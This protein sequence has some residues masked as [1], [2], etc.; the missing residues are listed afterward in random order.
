MCA[1]LLTIV[2]LPP[3]NCHFDYNNALQSKSP[4][5]AFPDR[6][7]S[8][9]T[10]LGCDKN[11]DRAAALN[12]VCASTK[13]VQFLG[14]G[15]RLCACVWVW[16]GASVCVLTF[17]KFLQRSEVVLSPPYAR[18]I[19]MHNKVKSVCRLFPHLWRPQW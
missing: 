10:P 3:S 9:S 15:Y 14:T 12:V 5:V 8:S 13:T 2:H 16:V 1:L 17:C 18:S 7:E 4:S 6:S 19:K 11:G